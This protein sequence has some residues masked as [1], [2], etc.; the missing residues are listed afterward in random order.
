MPGG[1]GGSVA[2]KRCPYHDANRCC[3]QCTARKY[4]DECGFPAGP[5]AEGRT[6]VRQC[7]LCF[8]AVERHDWLHDPR[9]GLFCCRLCAAIAYGKLITRLAAR[10]DAAKGA[11]LAELTAEL[12]GLKAAA[13]VLRF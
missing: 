7:P 5:D 11:L 4:A 8:A 12:D 13:L 1:G 9:H 10:V 2:L 3:I 6:P